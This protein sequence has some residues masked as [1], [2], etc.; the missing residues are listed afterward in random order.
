MTK[1]S[2]LFFSLFYPSSVICWTLSKPAL[3]PKVSGHG[4][5]NLSEEKLLLFGGLKEDRTATNDLWTYKDHE[6]N[7]QNAMAAGPGPRMYMGVELLGDK[8]FVVGGWDPE[9]KGSGGTFKDEVWSLDPAK[10]E[11]TECDKLPCGPISRHTAV[12][13]GDSIIIHTFKPGEEGVVV[14]QHDGTSKV[15]ATTGDAPAGMSMC[16]AAALNDHQMILFGGSTKTQQMSNDVFVLDTKTWK[17]TKLQPKG[18]HLPSPRASSCMARV[19][20]SSVLVFGGASLKPEGYAGGAGLM[21]SN[22]TYMLKV[23][24]NTAEWNLLEDEPRPEGRLACTLNHL[25]DKRLLLTGGWDPTSA[26]TF[27][28]GC[29][30]EL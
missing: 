7:L 23:K 30:F 10:L 1:F 2:L 22:D 17:W 20:D 14:L 9:A 21:G 11:W 4:C 27:D 26:E 28:D 5:C 19:D 16:S 3:A 18:K 6:W 25:P 24:G 8:V 15:Q 29:I 13:V 12:A